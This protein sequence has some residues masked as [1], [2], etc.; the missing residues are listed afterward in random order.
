M[1]RLLLAGSR[2]ARGARSLRGRRIA[3]IE[4]PT[5]RIQ[6]LVGELL[7]QTIGTIIVTHPIL[8]SSLRGRQ[9][10]LA[11]MLRRLGVLLRRCL[12]RVRV[13]HEIPLAKTGIHVILRSLILVNRLRK[14][15]RGGGI[16]AIVD[17]SRIESTL[18]VPEIQVETIVVVVGVHCE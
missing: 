7:N 9:I 13:G 12:R 4:I 14:G 3:T 18:I 10:G 16:G 8:V 2:R 15:G 6:V 1:S 5:R 17:S 11:I